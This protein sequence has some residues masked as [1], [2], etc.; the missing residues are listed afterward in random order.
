MTHAQLV[1]R[2][3]LAMTYNLRRGS[4]ILAERFAA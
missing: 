1:F 2:M 4:R 3:R